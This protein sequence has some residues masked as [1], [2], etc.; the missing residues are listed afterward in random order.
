[1]VGDE[2]FA[3]YALPSYQDEGLISVLRAP[4]YT[5]TSMCTTVL[6]ITVL[7]L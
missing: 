4:D 3:R 2:D 1:M 7:A 6:D 5:D